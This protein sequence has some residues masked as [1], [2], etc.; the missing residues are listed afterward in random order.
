MFGRIVRILLASI[1]LTM[2][3]LAAWLS[4]SARSQEREPAVVE[5]VVGV[6]ARKILVAAANLPRGSVLSSTSLQWQSWP[7]SSLMPGH[8]SEVERPAAMTALAGAVLREPV[9]KGQPI[10]DD[11]LAASGRAYLSSVL[12]AGKRAMAIRISAEHAAGGFVLPDDRVDVIG[13]THIDGGAS[14]ERRYSSHTILRNVRVLAIDQT[15]GHDKRSDSNA[16]GGAKPDLAVVGKTA[17]LEVDIREAEALAAGEAAG[18]LVL[19]LRST[20]DH[21]EA[22]AASVQRASAGVSIIRAGKID[23]VGR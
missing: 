1:A 18:A 14:S 6:P 7:E 23:L 19:S 2:G 17:T 13:V 20:A 10:S 16:G 15:V 3:A 9:G 8:I 11:F 5:R 12:P 22:A 21:A 4:L